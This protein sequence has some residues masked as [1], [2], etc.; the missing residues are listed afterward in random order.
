MRRPVDAQRI[1]KLMA[2]LGVAARRESRIYLVGGATAVLTGWR[3]STIDVDLKMVPEDDNVLRSIPRLKEELEINVELA[4]PDN[5]IP[6]VPGWEGRS[7]FVTREGTVSFL[8]YDFF[9]QALSKLERGHEK[10]LVD[11]RA[12]RDRG[13]IDTSRLLGYLAE[14]EPFL[15]RYP[16]VDPAAFRRAVDAFVNGTSEAPR[17]EV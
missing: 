11:V 16:A 13:L 15:Y 10:D 4:S 7:K 2:A 8:H 9:A 6:P 3:A 12:M 5:F 1:R 14:I 17:S